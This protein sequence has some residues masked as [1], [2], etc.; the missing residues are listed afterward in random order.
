MDSTYSHLQDELNEMFNVYVTEQ[1]ITALDCHDYP[2]TSDET[3]NGLIA[4]GTDPHNEEGEP[5]EQFQSV[6]EK[7]FKQLRDFDTSIGKQM[8]V[9]R[10]PKVHI[11]RYEEG[12]KSHV[13]IKAKLR[14]FKTAEQVEAFLAKAGEKEYSD[15]GE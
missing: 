1:G 3:L 12:G 5:E 8:I 14:Y 13:T 4:I 9:R 15:D 11:T 6:A 7:F 2:F 10:S